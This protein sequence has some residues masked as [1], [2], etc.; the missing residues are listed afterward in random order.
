LELEITKHLKFAH[1]LQLQLEVHCVLR[2]GFFLHVKKAKTFLGGNSTTIF[3]NIC[4]L[5]N[6]LQLQ[7]FVELKL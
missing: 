2:L 3:I 6:V 5:Q 1:K 4:C 7:A